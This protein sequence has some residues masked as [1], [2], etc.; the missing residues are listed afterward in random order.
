M[1]RAGLRFR[2]IP[3]QV[4]E[5][6]PR[7]L[8]PARLVNHLAL[9]KA[10]AVAKQH[11]KAIVIG[12]DTLVFI[13]GHAIGKPRDAKHARKILRELSGAWQ[14]VYTGVAVV[15]NSGGFARTQAAVSRVKFRKLTEQEIFRASGLHLDKAGAYA[16]QGKGDR[17]VEKIDGDYDNVVG[18]PMRVVRMLLRQARHAFLKTVRNNVHL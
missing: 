18:L 4:H 16:V 17:F 8:T 3:S 6:Q 1:R 9:K 10:L 12:A 11:P 14:R 13:N 2:V 5:G 15:V 7:G